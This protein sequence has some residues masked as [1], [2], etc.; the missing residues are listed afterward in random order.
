MALVEG[1]AMH[2]TMF[3]AVKKLKLEISRLARFGRTE[4]RCR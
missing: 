4:T 2:E 3:M 1:E